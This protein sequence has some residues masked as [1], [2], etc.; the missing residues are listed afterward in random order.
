[1]AEFLGIITGNDTFTKNLAV[2][3]IKFKNC[4]VATKAAASETLFIQTKQLESAL[5]LAGDT[6]YNVGCER[7]VY[8]ERL[9]EIGEIDQIEINNS[10]LNRKLAPQSE[11][12]NYI[13]QEL[14]KQQARL[15]IQPSTQPTQRKQLR[16]DAKKI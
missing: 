14:K 8:K 1:M 5:E 11:K 2:D 9:E 10:I 7:D 4:N 13:L 6:I 12:N 16:V 15:P 3:L